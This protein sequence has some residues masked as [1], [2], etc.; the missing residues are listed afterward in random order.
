MIGEK[1]KIF[2]SQKRGLSCKLDS[3]LLKKAVRTALKAEG[4]NIPC[5]VSIYITDD[6]EIHETNLEFRGVDKSTDVLSFPMQEF[7]PGDF[8]PDDGEID[9]ETG[10][11]PLGD[12]MIS[13]E[14][15]EKQGEEF[16]HS[17]DREAAYLTVHSVL[18]LLGYDHLD[19]GEQKKQMRDREKAIMAILGLGE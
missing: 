7:V 1:Y 15:A 18:H 10:R 12:I 11:I 2:F 17:A 16:G 9:P 6:E 5:E 3:R 13:S 4:V 14:H 8:D 19:E